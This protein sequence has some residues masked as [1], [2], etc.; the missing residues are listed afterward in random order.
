[1]TNFVLTGMQKVQ[2]AARAGRSVFSVT[3]VYR[4]LGNA[5]TRESITRAAIELGIPA[6]PPS[7]YETPLKV[8]PSDIDPP[9]SDI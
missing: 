1:M 8:L 9:E 2:L 7:I 6:P 4:G 3:R 5:Y